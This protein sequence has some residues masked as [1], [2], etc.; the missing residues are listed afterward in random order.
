MVELFLEDKDINKMKKN[1]EQLLKGFRMEIIGDKVTLSFKF[2]NSG[3]SISKNEFDKLNLRNLPML[4]PEQFR[5]ENDDHIN[6]EQ[7]IRDSYMGD[8]IGEDDEVLF[9]TNEQ[10]VG[11]LNT[12]T[13][14]VR[15]KISFKA[16]IKMALHS[17]KYAHPERPQPTWVEVIGL[18]TGF[19]ENPEDPLKTCINIKDAHPVGHGDAVTAQI[20][21][22]NSVVKVFKEKAKGHNILGW[23]HSHP[24]YTPF[25]SKT[26]FATQLRYQKLAK[27]PILQQP[28][29]LVIDP[30]E[31]TNTSYG[32]KIF[33]LKDDYKTWD[34]PRFKVV[35]APVKSMPEMIKT[36][37]PLTTGKA[38]FL[39][40]EN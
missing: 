5:V 29:A 14:P 37:L 7:V 20:Q 8:S 15:V 21:D 10:E 39:E 38:V 32:F 11:S 3:N 19:I 1:Y 33:R 31:I 28:I 12:L 18:M 34:E 36:L 13:D 23:Y 17:L 26:D 35:D 24:S 40:Y 9:A 2:P 16:Y 30:T 6:N 22:P 4:I 27:A 25:M